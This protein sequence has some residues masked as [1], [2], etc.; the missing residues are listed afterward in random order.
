MIKKNIFVEKT[1]TKP[2]EV[3]MKEAMMLFGFGVGLVSGALLYKYCQG[4]KK[5]VDKGEKT[6]MEEA[7]KMEQ[8]VGEAI[9][10][11]E[12]KMKQKAKQNKEN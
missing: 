5:L 7:Q 6:V 1:Q 9:K 10:Q 3:Q 12:T 4:A 2:K 8:K 11:A